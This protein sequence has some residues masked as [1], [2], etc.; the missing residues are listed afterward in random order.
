MEERICER[1]ALSLERK[2]EEVID[3]ESEGVDRDEPEVICTGSIRTTA[4]SPQ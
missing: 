2:S 3:G 1:D 4:S